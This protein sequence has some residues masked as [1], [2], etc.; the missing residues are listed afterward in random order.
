MANPIVSS[1]VI[2]FCVFF[3][4]SVAINLIGEKVASGI[5][6]LFGKKDDEECENR[7]H[8]I[9]NAVALPIA[10]ALAAMGVYTKWRRYSEAR[11]EASGKKPATTDASS[12]HKCRPGTKC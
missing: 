8:A 3:V 7:V 1:L 2:I 12:T 10:A 6:A 9:L 4:L 11:K 5:C